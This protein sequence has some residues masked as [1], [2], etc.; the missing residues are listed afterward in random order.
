MF[1]K[2]VIPSGLI[3]H[4]LLQKTTYLKGASKNTFNSLLPYSLVCFGIV[5]PTAPEYIL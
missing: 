3:S 4:L 2:T 1:R 5:N